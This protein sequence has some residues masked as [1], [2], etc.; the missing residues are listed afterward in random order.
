MTTDYLIVVADDAES[1]RFEAIK[2]RAPELAIAF[3]GAR[4]LVLSAQD[5]VAIDLAK[6]GVVL[7]D[8]FDRATGRPVGELPSSTV[9][10][11]G[12]SRGQWLIDAV[13]GGYIA[14]VASEHERDVTVLRDPSGAASAY[15]ARVEGAWW[16]FSG[17]QIGLRL[18][19]PRPHLDWPKVGQMLAFPQMRGSCTGLRG[20]DELSPGCRLIFSRGADHRREM[21]WSPWSFTTR[22]AQFS[23]HD[24]AAEAVRD[25][26]ML[27][28][29]GWGRASGKL[30]LELS[31]GLDSSIIACALPADV[32]ATLVN[33][34]T[35]TPEG[36]ERGYAAIVAAVARRDLKATPQDL[37]P[38]DI[39]RARAGPHPR[40]ASQLL[41]QPI[42]AAFRQL[43]VAAGVETFFSGLGGDNVFCAL[44]TAAPSADALLSFGF[45]GQFFTALDD[46][47]RQHQTTA[48]H[49]L[50]LTLRKALRSTPSLGM[51]PI[52]EFLTDMVVTDVP[53]H[54]WLAA[55]SKTLPGRREHVAGILVA[56]SFLDRY[57]HADLA[58]VRFPLL[59]Q[60]VLEACLRTPTW[61]WNAGGR[62]RA[63]A[64]DA[65]LDRLPPQ[66]FHRQTKGGLNVFMGTI[67]EA[68]RATLSDHLERGWL[69]TAGLVDSRAIATALSTPKLSSRQM[70]RILHLADAE[71]WARTW[72]STGDLRHGP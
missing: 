41:L 48:W 39:G 21:A 52:R 28:V 56:L 4:I 1:G 43:G 54:P 72:P 22:Q 63:V 37:T 71:S 16:I 58:P 23:S 46:L 7:G 69:A 20:I 36:D 25:A 27:S 59:A 3:E 66:I 64:R 51:Q 38:V 40:P 10:A 57:E 42:E 5:R 32:D 31:G 26:V 62:N 11:I 44:T 13:W 19:L 30:A 50:R 2:H 60:P 47:C 33:F 29:G 34:H 15:V 61:M 55:P 6:H 14:I 17:L 49:A 70:N 65:F 18:G 53:D 8:V 68:N 24:Q 12:V 45:N 9:Q 35:A 67:F